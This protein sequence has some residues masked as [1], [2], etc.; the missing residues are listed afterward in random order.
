ML[1]MKEIAEKAGVSVATVSRVF[2]NSPLVKKESRDLVLKYLEESNYEMNFQARNLRMNKSNNIIV[3]IPTLRNPL[4]AE[5]LDGINEKANLMNYNI[6][7]GSIEQNLEKVEPYLQMLKNRQAEGI[8]FVSK[9]FDEKIIKKVFTKYPVVLCNE[10]SA[11]KKIPTVSIDNLKASYEA[12]QYL[13]KEK[14]C[15]KICFISGHKQSPS[16]YLRIKGFKK[17][18][19]TYNL[20]FNEIDIIYGINSSLSEKEKI[21]NLIKK[22]QYDGYLVNSDIK[23]AIVLKYLI[24]DM[25]QDINKINLISFDGSYLSEL[26]TPSITSI[27]QPMN[28]IGVNAIDT[29]IAQ[30]EEKEFEQEIFL[31]YKLIIRNT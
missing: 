19:T 10:K 25:H 4:F 16:T 2:N 14:A 11:T 6:L 20:Q 8:I 12:T 23:S 24:E 21:I 30:I 26:L 17:A 7:I 9:T 28:E 29:L 31:P 22:G 3:I 13:I 27:V 18:L 1:S 5:I 15:S